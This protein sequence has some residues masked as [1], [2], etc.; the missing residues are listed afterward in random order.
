LSI[1]PTRHDAEAKKWRKPGFAPA[2]ED[3][4]LLETA[5][6]DWCSRARLPSA[7]W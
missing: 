3:H 7:S 5:L 2:I 4:D 1:A 6:L